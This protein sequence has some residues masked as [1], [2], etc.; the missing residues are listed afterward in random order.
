M[1]HSHHLSVKLYKKT[2]TS[3]EPVT[4]YSNLYAG[5][6]A[7]FRGL[8]CSQ[9]VTVR[10]DTAFTLYLTISKDFVKFKSQGIRVVVVAPGRSH[11]VVARQW[12]ITVKNGT[13]KLKYEIPSGKDG[14]TDE[15]VM[16]Q[17][18][19]QVSTDNVTP[20]LG[21]KIRLLSSR[22]INSD[23]CR[24][25]TDCLISSNTEICVSQLVSLLSQSETRRMSADLY[26]ALLEA[27]KLQLSSS[28]EFEH[29]SDNYVI[30]DNEIEKCLATDVD[31]IDITKDPEPVLDDD[32][33]I[34]ESSSICGDEGSFQDEEQEGDDD[35]D[36]EE[37]EAA[38]EEERSPL[39]G[40]EPSRARER[41]SSR[42]KRATY[43]KPIYKEESLTDDYDTDLAEQGLRLDVGRL[44]NRTPASDNPLRAKQA[45]CQDDDGDDEC[46]EDDEE[47][48]SREMLKKE[49]EE[50][51]LDADHVLRAMSP[52]ET[53]T[54]AEI[55]TAEPSE[56]P[57]S[58]RHHE[59]S[60]EDIDRLDSELNLIKLQRDEIAY[61]TNLLKL[62]R[63]DEQL[64]AQQK[65]WENQIARLKSKKRKHSS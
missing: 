38:N 17:P 12:W 49:L 52:G 22:N 31:D 55:P 14:L 28:S 6:K 13:G 58:K 9:I 35:A 25:T 5:N 44:R 45:H 39:G 34:T 37:E 61:Q 53:S 4:E 65:E 59:D 3:L 36:D 30:S 21:Q 18:V 27:S 2:D 40:N 24:T 26:T 48:L 41:R 29:D 10:P 23:Q 16:P 19:G 32:Y 46:E 1:K 63:K 8:L 47:P 50:Q 57:A 60:D 51:C 15:F 20:C 54:R 56:R 43:K 62:Q 42:L 64:K 33:P 7:R 11:Q